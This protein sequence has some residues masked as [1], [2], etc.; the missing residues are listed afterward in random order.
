MYL[1]GLTGNIAS[2]KSTVRKMLEDLGV[3]AIDA[4]ALSHAVL[5]KGTRAW[6][7]V[8]DSFGA[9]ILR[10]DEQID[11]KKLGAVVFANPESLSKLESIV[12]PAVSRELARLL[13]EAKE[14]VVVVEA[15][16]L[17]EAGLDRYCDAV[18]MVTAPA[19]EA[20]RRLMTDRGLDE[21]DAQ[22][23]LRAQPSIKDKLKRATLFIDNGG[24]VESTRAQVKEA[25]AAIRPELATDKSKIL[26]ALANQQSEIENPIS[27]IERGLV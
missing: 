11:R 2:G 26:S 5:S 10:P 7:E 16:K 4:D 20:K 15:V 12:H 14:P 23:R 17:I 1:I 22:L 24:S 27:K 25:F 8:I 3:R 13:S 9:E 6:R 18:W 21:I 19:S